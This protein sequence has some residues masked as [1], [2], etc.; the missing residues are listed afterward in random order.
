MCDCT[1]KSPSVFAAIWSV[2]Q[3]EG[4]QLV[5]KTSAL[6]AM[7]QLKVQNYVVVYTKQ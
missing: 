1:V 6:S 3:Q 5:F 4:G 2:V 7:A